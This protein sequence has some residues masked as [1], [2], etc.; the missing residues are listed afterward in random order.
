MC[1]DP[2]L[3][4][5]LSL[6]F[7]LESKSINTKFL[8]ILSLKSYLQTPTWDS[9]YHYNHIWHSRLKI[10][11]EALSI[12]TPLLKYL[13]LKL[14]LDT[15]RINPQLFRFLR[16]RLY[17]ETPALHFGYQSTTTEEFFF[18][19]P[20]WELRYKSGM[21]VI[22]FRRRPSIVDHLSEKSCNRTPP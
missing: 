19:T 12:N 6:L 11:Q 5:M 16:L 20:S 18:M 13:S 2:Q 9:K 14:D 17:Q 10:S 3:L 1:I 4:L 22:T 7:R 21:P 15:L 8:R